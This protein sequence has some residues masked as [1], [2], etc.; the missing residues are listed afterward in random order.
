M[1]TEIAAYI[2]NQ[3]DEARDTAENKARDLLSL[4]LAISTLKKS[5]PSAPVAVI[6]LP[7][8]DELKG[9]HHRPRRSQHPRFGTQ[10]LGVDLVIDDTPE[11]ITVSLLR[12]DPP[13]NRPPDDGIPRQGWPH[14]AGPHRRSGCRQVQARSR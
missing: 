11:V 14:P 1:S 3:E 4:W 13:R 10:T 9:P 8:D 12:S 6:A 7:S 5:P 2:K